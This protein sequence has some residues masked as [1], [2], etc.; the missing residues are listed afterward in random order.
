MRHVRP[1]GRLGRWLISLATGLLI[2]LASVGL[3]AC[4][5][6]GS[7]P[8]LTSSAQSQAA[9]SA[10]A[11][12]P[13]RACGIVQGSGRLQV[14]PT[15]MGAEQVEQCFWQAFQH[16]QPATLIFTIK[17]LNTTLTRTFTLHNAHGA[18]VISDARQETTAGQPHPSP[19]IYTCAGLTRQP[20]ALVF[21]A[22][23]QDGTIEVMGF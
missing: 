14:E 9:Q 17:D 18:C 8:G 2:V 16:C 19:T 10:T 1:Q 3:A 11:T 5:P 21:T 15:D 13:A 6:A 12:T 22:C 4:S 7:P 20:H 23:G